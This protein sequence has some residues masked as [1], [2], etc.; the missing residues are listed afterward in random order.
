MGKVIRYKG[1]R[2]FIQELKRVGLGASGY[3]PESGRIVIFVTKPDSS[4]ELDA[5]LDTLDR[6]FS[7]NYSLE[8]GPNDF[9]GM[10]RFEVLGNL[11]E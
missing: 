5:L 1:L 10:L 3:Q 6:Y 4:E 2:E 7:N 11:D 9:S 8:K